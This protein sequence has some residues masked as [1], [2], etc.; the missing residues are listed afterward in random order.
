MV[1]RDGTPP[2]RVLRLRGL[3]FSATEEQ[4]RQFFDPRPDGGS[5]D[6]CEPERPA[7]VPQSIFICRRD[8][9]ARGVGC[10]L[11]AAR[12][13]MPLSGGSGHLTQL[14]AKTSLAAGACVGQQA[15]G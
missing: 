12:L 6:D 7:L 8:G 4:V 15:A 2:S 1:E 10:E 5:G 3:P 9:E 11:A 14:W 13:H